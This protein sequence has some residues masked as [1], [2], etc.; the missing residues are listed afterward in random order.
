MGGGSAPTASAAQ[1]STT[2]AVSWPAATYANGSAVA[3]Y[4]V[5]R[6]DATT[7]AAQTVGA[8]CAGTVQALSCSES[9]VAIGVWKYSVTPAAGTWRGAE[10]ARSGS[11]T[12]PGL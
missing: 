11:V 5:H 4:I 10:S 1:L 8:G 12:V 2:V 3:G 9:G 6:Y 7:G